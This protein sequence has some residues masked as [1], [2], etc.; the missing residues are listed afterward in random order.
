MQP[1]NELQLVL[2]HVTH[3]VKHMKMT[4]D[5]GTPANVQIH[6]RSSLLTLEAPG[7]CKASRQPSEAAQS[8]GRT[9]GRFSDKIDH[10][11]LLAVVACELANPLGHGSREQH[12][13]PL[14]RDAFQDAFHI[15]LEAHVEHLICFIQHKVFDILQAEHPAPESELAMHPQEGII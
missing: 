5:S 1:V 8:I 14:V 12:C 6:E 3:N 7:T 10:Y 11:V 15:L 13:L 2:H 9:R 4:Q